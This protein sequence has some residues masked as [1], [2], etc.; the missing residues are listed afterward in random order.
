M[1]DLLVM[2]SKFKEECKLIDSDASR[3]LRDLV[4]IFGTCRTESVLRDSVEAD[5]VDFKDSTGSGDSNTSYIAVKLPRGSGE[6]VFLE[7]ESESARLSRIYL[8]AVGHL[9][10]KR[11][12][13][14]L[15]DLDQSLDKD[16]PFQLPVDPAIC[17]TP[18]LLVSLGFSADDLLDLPQLKTLGD[19]RSVVKEGGLVG[20]PHSV[21]SHLLDH[22]STE[23]S[24]DI[25]GRKRDPSF[26]MGQSNVYIDDS[27]DIEFVNL[28]L[29]LD[30]QQQE[31][32]SHFERKIK[33][34]GD[35]TL[36]SPIFISGGPGTGKTTIL[37]E[38]AR[39]I[40]EH[41]PGKSVF[42][43]VYNVALSKSIRLMAEKH[44]VG[45]NNFENWTANSVARQIGTRCFPGFEFPYQTRTAEMFHQKE[46]PYPIEVKNASARHGETIEITH[47]AIQD[48]FAQDPASI[49]DWVRAPS[50]S[51][52]LSVIKSD[53]LKS[54]DFFLAY[55]GYKSTLESRKI[56]M[57]GPH[58]FHKI[59][60]LSDEDFSSSVSRLEF[61]RERH[62]LP[63]YV[64]IDESQD[65]PYAVKF[66]TRISKAGKGLISAYDP[67]QSIWNYRLD[68]EGMFHTLSTRLGGVIQ[69][70]LGRT[71]SV[72]KLKT[73]HRMDAD[74]LRAVND[75][76]SLLSRRKLIP[77]SL[78][79]WLGTPRRR[80]AGRMPRL[81]VYNSTQQ[82]VGKVEEV[83]DECIEHDKFSPSTCAILG[84]RFDELVQ[85]IS[86]KPSYLCGEEAGKFLSSWT[87]DPTS[88]SV[89]YTMP[90]QAK[91]LDL[92]STIL[93]VDED[94]VL[95]P[96]GAPCDD[97]AL[98]YRMLLTSMTRALDRLYVFVHESLHQD[99]TYW[100]NQLQREQESL[101]DHSKSWRITEIRED[102]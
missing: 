11:D 65:L 44:Q 93:I 86:D 46:L 54:N 74:I 71:D 24:H 97:E 33:D 70:L 15:V 20:R 32:I 29:S 75:L 85:L 102:L 36:E 6:Y 92:R 39:V 80:G 17:I 51:K 19:L 22:F 28:Q 90:Y 31:F 83:L 98:K 9:E 4:I 81:I 67:E 87:F 2:R 73:N 99:P 58:L 94:Q 55:R 27:G 8:I 68:A 72:Y 1:S 47:A 41:Q 53:N 89:K 56:V 84:K 100:S 96:P 50:V 79:E 95:I 37:L 78:K 7:L 49:E 23:R 14:G 60:A 88:P 52:E 69:R 16:N 18:R 13:L 12:Q 25:T 45:S 76:T 26:K 35:K 5:I 64:L 3:S 57:Q 40:G 101:P 63:D 77:R 38:I 61:N 91:G 66:A 48:L 42:A 82:L 43:M 10:E 59:G 21:C 30:P 62:P 34:S